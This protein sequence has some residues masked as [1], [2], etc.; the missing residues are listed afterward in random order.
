MV[1][2]W[3]NHGCPFVQKHYGTG[4]M[5]A[6]QRDA[7]DKGIVWLSVISS[8]PG[9]QGYVEGKEANRLSRERDAVPTAV[10]LDPKGKVGRSYDARTTP[11]MYVIDAA[12]TLVYM[13]GIDDRPTANWADVDGATNYVR[14]AL[15]DV[16]AGRP[17]ATP[18]ARPYGCSVK[19]GRSSA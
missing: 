7:A 1:L 13:G 19:Y 2:E 16:A 4:N 11:H 8:A 6:L 10:L 3:T 5:Q 12:G 9:L 17:V 14:A 15:D 18:T